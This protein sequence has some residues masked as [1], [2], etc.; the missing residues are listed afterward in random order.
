MRVD[1]PFLAWAA[2]SAA[3]CGFGAM[4]SCVIV[5]VD[6]KIGVEFW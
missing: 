2:A 6:E 5:V 1:A 3:H 4:V